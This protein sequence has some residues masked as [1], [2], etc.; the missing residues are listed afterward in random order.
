MKKFFTS[1]LLL[2][3]ALSSC[4]KDVIT[5]EV[6]TSSDDGIV[7]INV[8]A[9]KT[10]GVDIT[11]T[12]LEN[13]ESGVKLHIIDSGSDDA[14]TND[15]YDFTASSS[16]WS[17]TSETTLKWSDIDFP[18]NFYSMH[19]GTS[20]S[21]SVGNGEATLSYTVT[22]NS[23]DHKDLVYHASTLS[24]IPSGGTINVFH[25][26]ALSKI[27]FYAGTGGNKAYIAKVSLVNVDGEGEVTIKP[28]DS[29]E[30][31]TASG[32]SWDNGASNNNTFLYY[33]IETTIPT[34]LQST[35]T[36]SATTNPIVTSDASAP[37]MILPQ[38]T[39]GAT[40]A[41]IAT[42]AGISAI[43][44]SYI[45]VIY[46]LTDSLDTP[47]VGYSAVSILSDANTYINED[48]T[49]TLYVK[50]AFPLTADFDA[51]YEYNIT[52]GLGMSGSTG[53]LLI[54]DNY[55]DKGGNNITL[56]KKDTSTSTTPTIPEIDTGDEILGDGDDDIDIVVSV[57]SWDAGD[58]S[59]LD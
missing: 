51:N 2:A 20:Q 16:D 26:H 39:T 42:A 57:N 32:V 36:T 43:T 8:T 34:A 4:S 56:T 7:T 41:Q 3:V 17:Q 31:S 19:D 5:N 52:L 28:V 13:S 37:L 44:G 45:E 38:E 30:L 1:A 25:K 46:Y 24:S 47:L 11:T 18:S 40:A 55:V 6:I 21:L 35:V 15:A 48:Q 53:G 33:A 10:R 49:K 27:N 12:A 23:T 58:D 22:G 54:T 50:A 29:S 14:L 59:S 9:A